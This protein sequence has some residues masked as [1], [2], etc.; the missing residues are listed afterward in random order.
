MITYKDVVREHVAK[1][2]VEPVVT[3]ASRWSDKPLIDLVLEAIDAGHP[4]KEDHIEEDAL[5]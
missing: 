5:T 2:G 1:F 3:G 4:Y